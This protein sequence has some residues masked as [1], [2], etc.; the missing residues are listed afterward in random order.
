MIA[1]SLLGQVLLGV[2]Q[3]L[4]VWIIGAFLMVFFIPILDG[5]NQAIWQAKVPPDVQG[6]VFGARVMIGGITAPLALLIAGPLA[7]RI[8]EPGMR[9]D[10]GVWN[11]L[12]PVF[13]TSPGAGMSAMIVLFAFIGVCAGLIALANPS[14]RNVETILPDH[15]QHTQT[16]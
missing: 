5:C 15:D 3:G 1:S 6:R 13:G 12:S 9:S 2:G 4:I 11:A 16:D 14:V 8:F 10:T 7:D